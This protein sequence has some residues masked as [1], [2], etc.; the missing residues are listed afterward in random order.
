VRIQRRLKRER[1]AASPPALAT[2]T[3]AM[4]AAAGP[5]AEGS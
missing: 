2:E 1:R 5:A 3:R 4:Q